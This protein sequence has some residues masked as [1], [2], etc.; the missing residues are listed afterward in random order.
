MAADDGIGEPLPVGRTTIG[1]AAKGSRTQALGGL[2][3]RNTR[4]LNIG[5][6]AQKDPNARAP[7]REL[8]QLYSIPG[9]R[10]K[11]TVLTA[12]ITRG[13]APEKHLLT[14]TALLTIARFSYIGTQGCE[15][16]RDV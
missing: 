15:V 14:F 1:S 12:L 13:A 4:S 10:Q 6:F 16:E 5:S 2:L 8:Y 9:L 7:L 3:K 11:S